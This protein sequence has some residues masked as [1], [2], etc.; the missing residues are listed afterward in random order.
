M[1]SAPWGS[2]DSLNSAC[3]RACVCVCVTVCGGGV[4]E[5][6]VGLELQ[7]LQCALF[8]LLSGVSG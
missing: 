8:S 3:V 2:A 6:L 5:G 1:G 4:E 7:E